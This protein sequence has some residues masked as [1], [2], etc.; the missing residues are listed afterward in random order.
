MELIINDIS[1]DNPDIDHSS[2]LIDIRAELEYLSKDIALEERDIGQAADWP[3]ILAIISGL[4]FLGK[5]IQ[6]NLDAWISLSQ[7]FL[8]LI[9][10]LHTRFRSCR[11]DLNGATLLA[12]TEILAR[13]DSINNINM[14]SSVEIPFYELELLNPIHLDHHPDALYIQTFRVNNRRLH[15]L[16]IKSKGTI[17]FHH[18]FDL[19]FMKF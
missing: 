8:T 11:I 12:L 2:V 10:K 15:V 6:E 14:A 19:N 17:E 13:E 5:P 7:R 4:Y 9:K 1:Y 3:V 18:I 16:G